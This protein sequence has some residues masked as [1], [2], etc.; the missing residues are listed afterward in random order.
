LLSYN[1]NFSLRGYKN[2]LTKSLEAGNSGGS[3]RGQAMERD[4]IQIIFGRSRTKDKEAR[5]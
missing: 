3:D 5:C 1:F 4:N 2:G